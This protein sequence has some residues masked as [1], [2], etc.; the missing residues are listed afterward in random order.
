MFAAVGSFA[1]REKGRKVIFPAN[2]SLDAHKPMFET[3]IT[4][5]EVELIERR[6]IR[7]KKIE[8]KVGDE[9]LSHISLKL[10]LNCILHNNLIIT[11]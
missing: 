11:R 9:S 3:D 7:K 4:V 8:V 10:L 6:R 1:Q 2:L 5:V